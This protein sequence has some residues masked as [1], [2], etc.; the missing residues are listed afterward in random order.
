VPASTYPT[1]GPATATVLFPVRNAGR[2]LE[3]AL[4]SLA[5]QSRRDFVVI[6]VNDGSTDASAAVLRSWI[7]AR[8]PGTVLTAP[9]EGVTAALIRAGAQARTKWWIRMDADDLA[10]PFRWERQA[11]WLDA[12]PDAVAVGSGLWRIDSHGDC[13]GAHDPPIDPAAIEAALLAG[14]GFAL[15]HPA[16]VLRADAVAAVGGYRPE[17]PLGQDLDLFLRL[18]QIGPLG[19][20]PE[21]LLSY[22]QH[23]AN[24]NFARAAEKAR[25]LR[26]ILAEAH[27]ERGLEWDP[28]SLPF[29]DDTA[30]AADFHRRAALGALRY[31][32]RRAARRHALTALRLAP[33]SPRTWRTLLRALAAASGE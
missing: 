26:L 30:K 19:N 18:A 12:H 4:A 7:P 1:P 31:S 21:R 8:L 23:D 11:A 33:L 28:A 32:T 15:C 29:R 10:A 16:A 17:F 24:T 25:L 9:G 22:R 27:G 3:P 6:A 20:V 2:F 14:D 5:A 13:I